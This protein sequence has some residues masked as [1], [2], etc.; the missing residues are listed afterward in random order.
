MHHKYDACTKVIPSQHDQNIKNSLAFK[1]WI[2]NQ[3]FLHCIIIHHPPTG[4]RVDMLQ[5]H[6]KDERQKK[7]DLTP[8]T[9]LS[10]FSVN[11]WRFKGVGNKVI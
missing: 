5:W 8:L 11:A 6:T 1:N 4:Y 2:L 3:H 10:M 7:I 9:S